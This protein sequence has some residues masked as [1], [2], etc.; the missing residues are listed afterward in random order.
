[1]AEPPSQTKAS[2]RQVRGKVGEEQQLSLIVARGQS[3]VGFDI[4][5]ASYDQVFSGSG[6]LHHYISRE[7][8]LADAESREILS[9]KGF[10]ALSFVQPSSAKNVVLGQV[11]S[12]SSGEFSNAATLQNNLRALLNSIEAMDE[13]ITNILGHAPESLWIPLLATGSAGLSY[14]QSAQV[15]ASILSDTLLSPQSS[16]QLSDITIAAPASVDEKTYD[17][18]ANTFHKEIQSAGLD[19]SIERAATKVETISKTDNN[20]EA[21]NP[22]LGPSENEPDTVSEMP[23]QFHSDHALTSADDDD[24]GRDAIAETVATN[25]S[26]VWAAQKRDKRPF[27]IHLSGR[28]GS[29]KSSILGFLATKLSEETT[30]HSDGW[31]V[32]DYNAW[33]MQE[34]GPPWWSLLTTVR[35]QGY[36]ALGAKGVWPRFCDWL[37][38]NTRVALPW[39]FTL[40]VIAALTGAYIVFRD[41]DLTTQTITTEIVTSETLE[42]GSKKTIDKTISPEKRPSTFFGSGSAWAFILTIVTALGSLGALAKIIQGWSKSTTETAEAVRDLQSDPTAVVKA[43]FERV[44]SNISRPVAVFIDDLDRC[45]ARYVVELLQS[46]QTAYSNVAVLY[47]VASDRDWI[48][49]AYNQVYR[50]FSPELTKPGAPLGYLFVKKIFQLSVPVPDLVASD[51]TRLAQALL[52][53]GKDVQEVTVDREERAKE[54]RIAAAAGDL[55]RVTQIQSAALAEGQNLADEVMR[56]V[57]NPANQKRLKHKLLEYTEVFDGNP[58]AIKRLINALTFRQ[59]YILT[60]AEDISFDIIARWT[61]LALRFPYTADV[62]AARATTEIPS[63]PTEEFPDPEAIKSILGTL[64]PSDIEQVAAFG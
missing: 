13:D 14:E 41:G 19:S 29:G 58:R 52:N 46:L 21:P 60:A 32:I 18:I 44:I 61:I 12:I 4:V 40:L 16:I 22:E 54:V 25:V 59:G 23:D 64:E 20:A 7:L 57:S 48:V 2:F 28:W 24:L 8:G 30:H 1:M 34:A 5:I 15:I 17:D 55:T 38:R 6:E 37:W 43:R 49:S 51:R 10:R 27:A 56:A 26:R 63:D 11:V 35:E 47:V 45:D 9:D 3:P 31:V 33:K 39:I 62:L 36:S 53:T 42:N 50:G